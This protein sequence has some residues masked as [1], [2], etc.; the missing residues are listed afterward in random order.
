VSAATR[1]QLRSILTR[2]S[3]NEVSRQRAV[4]MQDWPRVAILEA[5]LRRLWRQHAELERTVG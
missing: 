4:Q 5:E 1:N 3:D 2:A